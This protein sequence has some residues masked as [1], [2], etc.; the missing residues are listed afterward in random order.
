LQ[1]VDL[2]LRCVP[3]AVFAIGIFRPTVVKSPR[4]KILEAAAAFSIGDFLE[5]ALAEI[6]DGLADCGW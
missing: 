6:V 5:Q 3:D 2:V 1:T 4:D